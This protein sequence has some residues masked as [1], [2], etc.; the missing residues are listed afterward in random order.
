MSE[1]AAERDGWDF[2]VRMNDVD[3]ERLKV[4][5]GWIYRDSNVNQPFETQAMVFVP[6]PSVG[7]KREL[8]Q[9]CPEPPVE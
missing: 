7:E 9:P 1:P 2:V 6:A 5:G 4:T 3:T 8:D